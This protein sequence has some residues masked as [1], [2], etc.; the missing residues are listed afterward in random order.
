[1]KGQPEQALVHEW[2]EL[3]ELWHR[4]LSHVH[5]RALPMA[6]KAVSG[7]PK[8]QEKHEGI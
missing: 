4:I 1:M 6:R 8:I 2:I 5:Y 7:F 3:N